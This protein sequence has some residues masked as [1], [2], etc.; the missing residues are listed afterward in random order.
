[1]DATSSFSFKPYL[2]ANISVDYSWESGFG[3]G[4]WFPPATYIPADDDSATNSNTPMG[5]IAIDP[6][7]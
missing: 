1:M 7:T 5:C 3:F 4:A 6:S 2:G